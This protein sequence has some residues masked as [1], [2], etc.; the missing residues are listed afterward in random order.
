[1]RNG[2]LGV[3][4]FQRGCAAMAGRPWLWQGVRAFRPMVRTLALDVFLDGGSARCDYGP[5]P[6]LV[7]P[8]FFPP[9]PIPFAP[10]DYRV[11]GDL[12]LAGLRGPLYRL[13]PVGG[14]PVDGG[15]A[16]V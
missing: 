11:V 9:P 2:G 14:H 7:D 13:S 16:D 4:A 6:R 10:R 3:V 12:R 5:H 15:C 8:V 1:M